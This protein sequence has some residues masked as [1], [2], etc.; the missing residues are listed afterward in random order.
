MSKREREQVLTSFLS[1][2]FLE[3][4]NVNTA[5]RLSHQRIGRAPE[6]LWSAGLGT[7]SPT[8]RG[9]PQPAEL[10]LR[11]GNEMGSC[12][13]LSSAHRV[14]GCPGGVRDTEPSLPETL[15]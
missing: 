1:C 7:S 3:M 6:M 8:R 4:K 5:L 10:W 15:D 12:A 9:Q 13:Q 14:S 2:G 11:L